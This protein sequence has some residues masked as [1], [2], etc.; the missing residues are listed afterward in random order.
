MALQRIELAERAR[1]SQQ[2]EEADRL[3][4]AIL[5][6]VSHDLRTP[7][8]IIKT[9]ASNLR[10]L[11]ERLPA[12]QRQELSETIETQ[13]DHLNKLIGNLLDLS[14][15]QAG[16]LMLN[17]ELNS[18]EEVMGDVAAYIWQTTGQER[19]QMNLPDNMPLVLFDY[20]LMLQ[21]L[22]N[23]VDNALRYEPPNSKI[24]VQGCVFEHKVLLKLVN[25]GETIA[26]EDRERIMEPFYH[27]KDGHIGL[28]LPI[29]KGIVEAHQGSLR[30]ED[31]SGGGATFVVSLPFDQKVSIENEV[32]NPGG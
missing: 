3:K 15:L 20:G 8:T 25:H 32:K 24:E 14:R 2:Y 21:A 26:P 6:A 1:V 11:G 10:T 27:G 16:A 5:H 13:A 7:I 9:S 19:I 28:G 4:T 17:R 29:A 18:L 22:T 31:T 23:L 30:V 12:N